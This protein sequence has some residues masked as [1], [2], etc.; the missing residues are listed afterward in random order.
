MHRSLYQDWLGK[1]RRSLP[2]WHFCQS[3]RRQLDA[4]PVMPDCL[5]TGPTAQCHYRKDGISSGASWLTGPSRLTVS[6]GLLRKYRRKTYPVLPVALIKRNRP[7]ELGHTLAVDHNFGPQDWTFAS[8]TQRARMLN[9]ASCSRA[10][11]SSPAPAGRCMPGF[12]IAAKR[13][14]AKARAPLWTFL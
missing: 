2:L 14:S 12:R 8:S 7:R 13:P 9:A 4:T 6:V 1:R 11:C 3:T 5:V 10:R